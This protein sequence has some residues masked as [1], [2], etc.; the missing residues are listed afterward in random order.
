MIAAR[1]NNYDYDASSKQSGAAS[2]CTCGLPNEKY[3]MLN[4]Q[5]VAGTPARYRQRP[6]SWVPMSI[7]SVL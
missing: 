3:C 1:R 7:C 2:M 5:H 4:V 6:Y